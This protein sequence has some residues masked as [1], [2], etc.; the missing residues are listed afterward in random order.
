MT[1]APSLLISL[2]TAAETCPGP[3]VIPWPAPRQPGGLVT[4]ANFFE[5]QQVI[6]SFRLP[7]G[8]P[9]AVGELFDRALKLYL[10]AWLDFDLVMAAKLAA[11]AA[12]EY[13]LRDR[14]LGYFREQHIRKSVAQAKN[15]KREQEIK[16]CFRSESISFGSL[17]KHMY[18]QDDLTND[19]LACARKYGGSIIGRLTNEIRPGLT[20][21]RNVRAHGNPCGSG[22]Q[23][24]LLDLVR[25]L[26]EYAY[27]HQIHA[28]GCN[29]AVT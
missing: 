5:W 4:F 28:A 14:Y 1:I 2:A 10:A 8:V 22:Y 19:K 9:L 17:L 3:R 6:L 11:F 13:S 18:L 16:A 21:L 24:G 20:E 15:K 7:V 12:L 27:R 23:S 25:D 26:V 29:D